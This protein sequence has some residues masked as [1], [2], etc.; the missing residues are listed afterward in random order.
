M[1]SRLLIFGCLLGLTSCGVFRWWDERGH[2]ASSRETA[3]LTVQ[4]LMMDDETGF[5][6]DILER[7]N[8]LHHYY[9]L[10]QKH[11]YDFDRSDENNAEKI[12]Q[13]QSYLSL[14]AI[15]T[16]TDEIEHEIYQVWTSREKDP[17]ALKKKLRLKMEVLKFAAVSKMASLS[18]ENLMESLQVDSGQKSNSI[19]ELTFTEIEM[20]IKRLKENREF[21]IFEKNI[22]H[23]AHVMETKIDQSDKT[24][25]RPAGRPGIFSGDEFPAKVWALTFNDGP[26]R[27]SSEIVSDLKKRSLKATF[28]QLASSVEKNPKLALKIKDSGM[29]LGSHS[30]NHLQ[31]TKVGAATLNHE[32]VEATKKIE[33]TVGER[34]SYFRLPYGAGASTHQIREKVADAGLVVIQWNVD[35]LDWVPQ[36]PEKIVARTLKLMGKTSKDAG[37]ILL[38]DVHERSGLAARSIMDALQTNG[39]R[40]CTI[41][42]I[43]TE[44]NEGSSTVCAKN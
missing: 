17:Q 42:Q 28:F 12:Y 1:K 6:D 36:N 35:S 37:I 21:I 3:S 40:S 19:K 11:L 33:E 38:H 5:A 41:D 44:M 22:E 24:Y 27:I 39:R 26:T 43:V 8:S 32:I 14:L 30:W 31:L 16:Q 13:S 4:H 23:L 9:V 20:E 10:A 25:T 15:R 18:M 29:G 2:S 34:V 7:L